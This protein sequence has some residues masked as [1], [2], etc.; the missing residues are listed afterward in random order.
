MDIDINVMEDLISFGITIL[1]GGLMGT[2]FDLYRAFRRVTKPKKILSF[3]ED[4]LFWII[5]IGIFFG[6]LVATTDGIPRGYVYLGC[7]LGL[8]F[9]MLLLSKLF[10]PFFIFIFKLIIGAINEIIKLIIYP[11]HQIIKKNRINKLVKIP[12]FI[13]KEMGRYIKMVSKKK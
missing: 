6:L 12:R 9:Y 1:I 4:L 8:G 3:I 13:C 7:L 10:L 2:L 5:I 11:I